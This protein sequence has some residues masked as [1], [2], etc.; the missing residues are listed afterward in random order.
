MAPK[1]YHIGG[2]KYV[3]AANYPKGTPQ[4]IAANRAAAAARMASA[5]HLSGV[6]AIGKPTPTKGLNSRSKTLVADTSDSTCF[7]DLRWKGGTAYM[8]FTDGYQDEMDMSKS[9]F[10]DWSD[11]DSLGQYWNFN[12]RPS[13]GEK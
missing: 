11:S 1:L 7:D 4:Q 12:L 6:N 10:R 2:G 5:S 9:D 3:T 8:T 13:T